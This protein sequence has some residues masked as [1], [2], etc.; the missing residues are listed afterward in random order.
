MKSRWRR[1]T[2]PTDG[3]TWRI[4]PSPR[5][6]GH[7][8]ILCHVARVKKS[9][10][11]IC[12]FWFVCRSIDEPMYSKYVGRLS[13]GARP[14]DCLATS[15]WFGRVSLLS[16]PILYLQESQTPP[17]APR[18]GFRSHYPFKKN[19]PTIAAAFVIHGDGRFGL[20]E[21][22]LGDT[23]GVAKDVSHRQY[24]TN[25]STAQEAFFRLSSD[26]S[27]VVFAVVQ[28]PSTAVL[29]DPGRRELGILPQ[30]HL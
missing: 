3:A 6:G 27:R 7:D 22:C 12:W 26:T 20:R 10:S 21:S 18:K 19:T 25:G 9:K 30:Q 23:H 11:V 8:A 28:S 29:G 13:D 1:L 16:C 17:E 2:S 24:T 4:P 5:H 14:A 15:P